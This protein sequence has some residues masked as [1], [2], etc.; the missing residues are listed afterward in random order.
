MEKEEKKRLKSMWEYENNALSRGFSIIAGVDEAGRGPLA[1]P[2]VAAAAILPRN[3]ML[4][5]CNDSNQLSPTLRRKLYD[6]IMGHPD[7]EVGIGTVSHEQIDQMNILRATIRAM[8]LAVT[9]L[10]KRPDFVL[11]DALF[12]L[13]LGIE[14]RG[15]IKGDS[16]SLSIAAAS[17]VAK[18]TRD[19][20][21]VEYD[22]EYPQYGFAKHKGYGTL[23]HRNMLLKHGPCPIHRKTFL[24]VRD[25]CEELELWQT[26]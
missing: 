3:L 20:L 17:I 12:I 24:P 25:Q 22:K 21:M 15:V 1:G 9:D 11:I 6:E 19:N 13:D 8:T 18:Q 2:V 26:D 16:R 7:I 10:K 4:E 14:N 5:K 23:L